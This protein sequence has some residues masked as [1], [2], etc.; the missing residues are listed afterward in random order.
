VGA[1]AV[2]ILCLVMARVEAIVILTS[3]GSST[4]QVL[5]RLSGQIVLVGTT[6]HA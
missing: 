1:L 4:S 3:M 2:G 6:L 5:T